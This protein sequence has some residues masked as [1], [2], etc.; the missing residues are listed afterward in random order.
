MSDPLHPSNNL[1]I[2]MKKQTFQL[3][4]KIRDCR[5]YKKKKLYNYLA[6]PNGQV[7]LYIKYK[8]KLLIGLGYYAS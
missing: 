1:T 8:Q 5:Q 4:E 3:L 7:K 2:V 6:L